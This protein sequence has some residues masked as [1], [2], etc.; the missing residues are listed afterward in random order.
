MEQG[1]HALKHVQSRLLGRPI[2]GLSKRRLDGLQ[3][4]TAVFLPDQP[5]GGH[6]GLAQSEIGKLAFQLLHGLLASCIHPSH[7][8]CRGSWLFFGRIHFPTLDQSKGIPNLVGKIP[9]LLAEL[10][11]ERQIIACRGSEQHAHTDT[12]C[13]ILLHQLNG[14][15]TVAQALG[16]FTPLL[17]P[18]NACVVNVFEGC[19]APVMVATHDH[20]GH[21]EK[22]DFWGRDK[23][24]GGVVI[25]HFLLLVKAIEHLDGPNP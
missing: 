24:V 2:N 11:V 17:V 14:V 23:V 25:R 19:F 15:G 10:F 12:I 22:H 8:S 18:H 4:P 7:G 20:P 3:V 1:Q 5:V 16:H 9:A 13:A 6:Q 21:P